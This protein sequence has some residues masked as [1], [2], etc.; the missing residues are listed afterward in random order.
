MAAPKVLK[1][2]EVST[3]G[4]LVT[5]LGHTAQRISVLM[6]G[7]EQGGFTAER[8]AALADAG[9]VAVREAQ[10]V[11]MEAHRLERVLVYAAIEPPKEGGTDV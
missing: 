4:D 1:P 2:Y 7:M 11:Y 3:L 5:E 9:L 10:E 8:L 6:H